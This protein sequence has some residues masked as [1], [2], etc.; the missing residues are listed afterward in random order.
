[1]PD[2]PDVF[3]GDAFDFT[4]LVAAVNHEPFLPGQVGRMGLFEEEGIST[5][6]VAIEERH[7][8]LEL[9]G[10]T[11]RGGPGE[12]IAKDYE[13]GRK[14]PVSHFQ[15]DDG[16]MAEE[17][18]GQR[19]FG[20]TSDRETLEGRLVQRSMRHFNDFD[21]TLEHQRVG[22]LKGIVTNKAGGTRL[23]L[24]T[25]FGVA[26]PATV[27]LD[28]ANANPTTGVLRDTCDRIIE[29]IE[30]NLTGTPY[31]GV[32]CLAGRNAYRALFKHPEMQDSFKGTAEAAFLRQGLPS[33][34]PFGNIVFERYRTSGIAGLI[35]DDELQFFPVARGLY[36][37]WF[38][39]ADY[40]DTVNTIGLPRYLRVFSRSDNKG[41]RMEVQSNPL[42]LCLKPRVLI[43]G[44]IGAA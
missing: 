37:T 28:L 22:A 25:E 8:T 42:S 36:K 11:A 20:S 12:T 7:G 39:P 6:D 13:K 41:Y 32:R 9:V 34:L 31:D 17:V 14:I 23:N 4:S 18:Q 30:D 35:G 15:R 24:F 26:Q 16:V 33:S 5:L 3:E 19:A 21:L 1:M 40:N 10:E 44:N 38:A 27:Y 2:F 43:K 29:T